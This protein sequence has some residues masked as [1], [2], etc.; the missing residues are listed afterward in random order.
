MA[1]RH[2]FGSASIEYVAEGGTPVTHLLGAKLLDL[3]PADV[4]RRYDFFADDHVARRTVTV[5]TGVSDLLATIRYE[6]DPAALKAMLRRGLRSNATL[7]YLE[8]AGGDVYPVKL[9]A[10][11][12]ASSQDETPIIRDRSRWRLGEWE[13]RV[14][15]RRVD[16]LTLDGLL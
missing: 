16:G 1:T 9:V 6:D 3:A 10:V 15:L 4:L 14:H 2:L 12:G 8:E 13:C 11:V 7:S 5:G